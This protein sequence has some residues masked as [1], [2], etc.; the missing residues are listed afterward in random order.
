MK[1][2][3]RG[4]F[5]RPPDGGSQPSGWLFENSKA[6][7]TVQD[8]ARALKIGESH[9]RCQVEEGS[10]LAAPI[11]GEKVMAARRGL[12]RGKARAT[13]V[14]R[15]H[16]RIMRF[17]VEAWWLNRLEDEGNAI[18]YPESELLNWWRQELRKRRRG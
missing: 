3:S 7:V 6:V 11:N 2:P 13:E 5:R 16:L 8:V 12:C 4:V 17:S 15:E 18:P 10:F 1:P 14:T 9:V